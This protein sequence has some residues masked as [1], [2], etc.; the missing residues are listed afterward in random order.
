M[1][2]R[3]RRCPEANNGRST[4]EYFPYPRGNGNRKTHAQPN[5]AA[6]SWESVFSG[7]TQTRS[8]GV[9]TYSENAPSSENVLPC[10]KPATWSPTAGLVTF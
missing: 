3:L 8:P 5:V 1:E 2:Q 9:F 10:R 7:T 6:S 4:C